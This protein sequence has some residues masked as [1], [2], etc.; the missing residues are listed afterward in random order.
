M[1]KRKVMTIVNGLATCY[2]I[3]VVF[4]Y[5]LGLEKYDPIEEACIK[6]VFICWAVGIGLMFFGLISQQIVMYRTIKDSIRVLQNLSK[7]RYK[8]Y[9]EPNWESKVATYTEEIESV[10]QIANDFCNYFLKRKFPKCVKKHVLR[11]KNEVNH[12]VD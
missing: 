5:L 6:V 7:L 1:T 3:K 9:F 4:F 2:M 10:R 8:A 11:M 12:I